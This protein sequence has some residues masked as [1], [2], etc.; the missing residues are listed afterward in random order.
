MAQALKRPWLA[1][2]MEKTKTCGPRLFSFEPRPND[3]G[4]LLCQTGACLHRAQK[5]RRF[6]VGTIP[7]RKKEE[8][9]KLSAPSLLGRGWDHPMF[10]Y[11]GSVLRHRF[12]GQAARPLAQRLSRARSG[13][14]SSFRFDGVLGLG[15]PSLSQTQAFGPRRASL[16][17]GV[18][19]GGW[20]FLPFF[21]CMGA[22]A[23]VLGWCVGRWG[24]WGFWGFCRL[25]EVWGK[26][27]GNLGRVKCVARKTSQRLLSDPMVLLF[28]CKQKPKKFRF[29]PPCLH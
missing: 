14:F 25:G 18:W 28:T 2:E 12:G 13:R 7:T 9:P 23:D 22:Y 24:F 1:W 6:D 27:G 4:F 10:C 11:P 19:G 5:D 17:L 16:R 26:F 29:H 8:E 20:G 21:F 3:T 15:L